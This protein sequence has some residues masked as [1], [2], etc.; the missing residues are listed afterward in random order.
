MDRSEREAV[1]TYIDEINRY[2]GCFM[3][4]V[5]FKI[6]E[7]DLNACFEIGSKT[8]CI[9]NV[10]LAISFLDGVYH[11]LEFDISSY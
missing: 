4:S 5:T 9:P 6:L 1:L 8:K 10:D 11:G 7:N 2:A 3:V